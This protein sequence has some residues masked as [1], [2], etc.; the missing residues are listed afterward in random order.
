MSRSIITPK[1]A[2]RGFTLIELLVVIAIIAI[3]AAILFP[4]FQKVRENARRASCQSN[5]KQI[6]LAI[7]QYTQDSDELYPQF[8]ATQN[9][10]WQ[11]GPANYWSR[12]TAPQNTFQETYPYSK[13]YGLYICPDAPQNAALSAGDHDTNYLPSAAVFGCGLPGF[14]PLRSRNLS[15]INAPANV[16]MVQEIFT[17]LGG[18]S[19]PRPNY[20]NG[21]FGALT[22]VGYA[23][24]NDHK[25]GN[26]LFVDG[27]VKYRIQST[28]TPADFGM[29]QGTSGHASTDG[30]LTE[31]INGFQYDPTLIAM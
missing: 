12:S 27:H 6:G 28:M 21:T 5:E 26:F 13:S 9:G 19:Y 11:D 23:I 2:H 17:Q 24:H 18:N 14:S 10:N 8:V 3:L 22:D 29:Q 31:S 4:V 1:P 7:I 16:V 30:N 20:Y 15:Q 25:G